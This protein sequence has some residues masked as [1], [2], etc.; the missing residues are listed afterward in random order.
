MTTT[1]SS[2][3]PVT[4]VVLGAA[5]FAVVLLLAGAAWLGWRAFA[6]DDGPVESSQARLSY[7]AEA[8]DEVA[9]SAID[10]RNRGDQPAVIES[11]TP[12]DPPMG[13]DVLG[14]LAYDTRDQSSPTPIT[15]YPPELD[16]RDAAGARLP[17]RAS[18]SVKV[19]LVVRATRPGRFVIGETEVRY[20]VGDQ[21]HRLVVP[22]R[23]AL[24]ATPEGSERGCA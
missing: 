13:L 3:S 22:A 24:C 9:F 18:S 17:P 21:R 20:R 1:G 7:T 16:A 5:A 12:V 10:L 4:I 23:I 11:V 19:A 15:T 14:A 8:F 6:G 2:R